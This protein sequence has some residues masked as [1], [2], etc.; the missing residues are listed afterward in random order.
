KRRPLDVSPVKHT[1]LGINLRVEDVV[2]APLHPNGVYPFTDKVNARL[3]R[4][5][6]PESEWSYV[7][8]ECREIAYRDKWIGRFLS[9][10]G[11]SEDVLKFLPS[12]GAV[13][14][15]VEKA[16]DWTYR[17]RLDRDE[18]WEAICRYAVKRHHRD[19]GIRFI[20][21]VMRYTAGRQAPNLLAIYR[22]L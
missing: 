7:R 18:D 12:E 22:D 20:K 11:P 6:L 2:T 9:L 10:P 8:N 17:Y 15:Y 5:S 4:W 16:L 13:L 14:T 1:T 21:G 19:Q 3:P